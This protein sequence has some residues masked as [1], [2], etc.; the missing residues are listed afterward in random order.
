MRLSCKFCGLPLELQFFFVILQLQKTQVQEFLQIMLTRRH[1][2]A[3]VMQ[4]IYAMQQN[5]N[6]DLDKELKVLQT[7][8][9]QMQDLYWLWCSLFTQLHL[10]A[11]QQYEV[12]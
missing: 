5:Q 6:Q 7:S 3:K 4:A 8:A 9:N 12:V 2:R 1:I 10:L 11:T